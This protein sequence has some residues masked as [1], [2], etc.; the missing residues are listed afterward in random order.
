MKEKTE[1]LRVK[2]SLIQLSLTV[3]QLITK[4]GPQY[5]PPYIK[6]SIFPMIT[7]CDYFSFILKNELESK[8]K[9]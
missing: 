1:L 8:N 9:K 5:K 3:I 2:D 4:P 7:C 6:F